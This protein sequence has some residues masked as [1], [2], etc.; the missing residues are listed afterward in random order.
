MRIYDIV[1]KFPDRPTMT[2]RQKG[3]TSIH[4]AHSAEKMFKKWKGKAVSAVVVKD[5]HSKSG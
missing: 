5:V 1:M 2:I 4:A 3:K